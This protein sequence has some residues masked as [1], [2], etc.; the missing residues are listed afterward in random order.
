MNTA[1]TKPE[2][3]PPASRPNTP[4]TPKTMPMQMGVMTA[5]TDGQIIS[6]C[7]PAVEISTQR[8]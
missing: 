2:A 3:R 4:G 7:A 6:C 1:N 8:T 5:S